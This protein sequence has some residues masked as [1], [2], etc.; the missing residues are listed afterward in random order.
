M[1]TPGTSMRTPGC[2]GGGGGDALLQPRTHRT[3][4]SKM[5][6]IGFI[7]VGRDPGAILLSNRGA[8]RHAA[9]ATIVGVGRPDGARFAKK[10]TFPLRPAPAPSTLPLGHYSP[11]SHKGASHE[12]QAEPTAVPRHQRRQRH[13]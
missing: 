4:S 9:I 6:R 2:G 13:R 5:R 3:I 10:P 11:V 1:F 7:L 8:R 12:S